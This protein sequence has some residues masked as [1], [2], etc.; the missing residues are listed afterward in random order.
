MRHHVFA[1]AESP[2][3][4]H[5]AAFARAEPLEDPLAAVFIDIAGDAATRS[6]TLLTGLG[7]DVVFYTSH[8]Y[9]RGLLARGRVDTFAAEVWSYWRRARRLPPLNLRSALKEKFGIRPWRAPFPRWIR[10]DVA[11]RFALRE[12]F[13]LEP[14]LADLHPARPEAHR[15]LIQPFW[16]RFFETWDA[17]ETGLPLDFAYPMFDR[18]LVELLFSF[19]PMPW[20]AD[21]YLL[22]E[23]MRGRLPDDVRLR[24]KTPLAGDPLGIALASSRQIVEQRLAAVPDLGRL[25]DVPVLLNDLNGTGGTGLCAPNALA[26]AAWWRENY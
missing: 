18:R 11:N 21:K 22:R 17:G 25:I 13:V 6:R 14:P 26:L 16:P 1:R 24:P 5:E 23:A 2:L 9:F 20:F 4:E 3:F 15:L 10:D 7:G 12:Q 19:P 8:R